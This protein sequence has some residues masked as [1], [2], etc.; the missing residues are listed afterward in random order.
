MIRDFHIAKEEDIGY[1]VGFIT[2]SFAFAQLLTG[3]HF[4]RLSDK[5]G[6]KPVILFGMIGTII[7]ILSFGLSKSYMWALLS[8][9]LCGLLNGNVGVLRCMMG[10]LTLGLSPKN[11]ARAFTLLPLMYGLGCVIGPMLGGYLS[12]PVRQHPN[13]FGNLGIFTDFLNEFP[14]FLPCFVSAFICTLGWI[15]GY[16]FLQETLGGLKYQEEKRQL[17]NEQR[18]PLLSPNQNKINKDGYNT[19]NN[20]NEQQQQQVEGDDQSNMKKTSFPPSK[21]E[22]PTLR[23]SLTPLVWSIS[24]TYAIYAFQV[25]FYDELFPIWSASKREFG[26]LGFV[27]NEIG[28]ALAFVGCTTLVTQLFIVPNLIHRYGL[29]RLYQFVQLVLIV[30]YTMQGFIRYL[31]DVPNL[32][33]Q[34]GTKFWV[35]VGLLFILMIK[36]MTQSTAFM[37]CTL[38]VNNSCHRLDALGAVNGFAQCCCSF[39][40]ALGPA[41]CG[42]LWSQ[43]LVATW[44]PFNVRTHITWTFL[45]L[46]GLTTFLTGLRLDPKKL[47]TSQAVEDIVE[48]THD[49]VSDTNSERT[50]S[51]RC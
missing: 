1:Y 14:Y 25:V 45:S 44:L 34:T 17:E 35:W 19:F 51:Q 29:V 50:I 23:E 4:G 27:E 24:I 12:N 37:C 16:F 46:V 38:I 32:D 5:I 31:Y 7:S 20:N 8:R 30:V 36:T 42:I 13:I 39:M 40:R 6:R 47:D 15:F 11:R 3:I 18:Q 49:H 10:E 2:A 28:T 26:G 41:C 22:P 9:T 48:D 43:S 33:G 21:P